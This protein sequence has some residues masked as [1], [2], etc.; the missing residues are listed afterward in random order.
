MNTDNH[1]VNKIV[2]PQ[3]VS[4]VP[5]MKKPIITKVHSVDTLIDTFDFIKV[6]ADLRASLDKNRLIGNSSKKSG[7]LYDTDPYNYIT[8][9]NIAKKLKIPSS[10]NK[11][12]MA[13]KIRN[14]LYEN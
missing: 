14:I 9:K 8:L 2:L 10:Y 4:L 1:T 11:A 5:E 3:H 7:F 13:M 6:V 12:E